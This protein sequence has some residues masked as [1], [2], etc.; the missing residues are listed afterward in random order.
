MSDGPSRTDGSL[1]DLLQ[2]LKDPAD[3]QSVPL[4]RKTS[5]LTLDPEGTLTG[6]LVVAAPLTR[7]AAARIE[8]EAIRRLVTIPGVRQARIAIVAQAA[9]DGG[10]PSS[11]DQ[12][13][14]AATS[15]A[16]LADVRSVIAVA[17]GK[18]GVGKS[19][20]AVNLAVALAE[21]GLS[22]GLMDADI[23]GPSLPLMLG[24]ETKPQLDAD[25][26]LVPIEAFGIR[27]MSMGYLIDADQAAI[28]RGP[29][30]AG[31][32]A[33]LLTDVAWGA[34]DVLVVDMPPGTGDA[35]LTLAQKADLAGA[36]IVSTPQDLALI[37]AR[38]AVAMF[39]RIEVPVL[40]IVEN[41]SAFVCPQCGHEAHLFGHGGAAREA[42]KR[43]VPFLG[44]VPLE[45]PVR[46][47]ADEGCPVVLSHPD[48]HAARALREIAEQVGTRLAKPLAS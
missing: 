31:A 22:V 29:M 36:V 23:Y 26:R 33:Q 6:Q 2:G 17:S 28:W 13:T 8:E 32:V 1:L 37:D 34:L 41:M 39:E 7:E 38:R 42:A 9:A 48:S 4:D 19:T 15:S 11:A 16:G 47:S 30:V 10:A 18:G 12:T 43:K 45:M 44:E 35:Q 25:R 27:T 20:V 3:G 14:P 24:R 46:I 21:S 40:G 5:R